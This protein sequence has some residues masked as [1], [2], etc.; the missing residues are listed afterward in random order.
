MLIGILNSLIGIFNSQIVESLSLV[1]VLFRE[2]ISH[3][4]ISFFHL[5]VNGF[6]LTSFRTFSKTPYRWAV[7]VG[8]EELK[9]RQLQLIN[10]QGRHFSPRSTAKTNVKSTITGRMASIGKSDVVSASV[11]SEKTRMKKLMMMKMIIIIISFMNKSQEMT[12]F[13][14]RQKLTSS[15]NQ[16]PEK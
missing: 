13:H 15:M 10:S 7:S 12:V 9:W 11:Y 2:A 16:R 8:G 1:S 5:L 14:G 3:P 6:S 4:Y